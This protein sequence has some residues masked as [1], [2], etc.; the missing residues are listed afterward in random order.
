MI[1]NK[2]FIIILK[3]TIKFCC[4]I[5]DNGSHLSQMGFHFRIFL[6]CLLLFKIK[7]FSVK[8]LDLNIRMTLY[9]IPFNFLFK[10]STMSFV[11]ANWV[12]ISEST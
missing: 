6:S 10:S 1:L 2:R 4:Q 12:F 3:N 11:S 8:N 5:V 9:K 7:G